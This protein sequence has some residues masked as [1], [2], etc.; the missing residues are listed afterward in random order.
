VRGSLARCFEAF[1]ALE[2]DPRDAQR[3]FTDGEISEREAEQSVID[4]EVNVRNLL[5][6]EVRLKQDLE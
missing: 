2:K 5:D 3:E 4:L 6:Q 1:T